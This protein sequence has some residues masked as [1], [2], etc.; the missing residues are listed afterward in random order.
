MYHPRV[1]VTHET[2]LIYDRSLYIAPSFDHVRCRTPCD[3][4]RCGPRTRPTRRDPR[5]RPMESHRM[6]TARR[7]GAGEGLIDSPHPPSFLPELFP[8]HPATPIFTP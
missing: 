8:H 3:V 6:T 5:H 1:D 4:A 7:Q 2:T